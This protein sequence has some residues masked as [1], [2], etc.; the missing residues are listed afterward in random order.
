MWVTPGFRVVVVSPPGSACLQTQFHPSKA[1]RSVSRSRALLA[2]RGDVLQ[3]PQRCLDWRVL[4]AGCVFNQPQEVICPL[5]PVLASFLSL[6]VWIYSRPHPGIVLVVTKGH[7]ASP[8]PPALR[9]LPC[10]FPHGRWWYTVLTA[11]YISITFTGKNSPFWLCSR[12]RME[13][14]GVSEVGGGSQGKRLHHVH[15][16]GFKTRG[17]GARNSLGGPVATGRE[18][19]SGNGVTRLAP[20]PFAA[21]I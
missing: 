3:S 1:A 16:G 5:F 7:A 8:E 18:T 9:P 10:V 4:S 19:S 11:G 14:R 15:G 12:A 21:T 2:W 17:T 13:P 6:T 20:T